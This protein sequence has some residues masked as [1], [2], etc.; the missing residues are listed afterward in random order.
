MSFEAFSENTLAST[1]CSTTRLA[2]FLK[3]QVANVSPADYN[4]DET[5]GTLRYAS[6]AKKIQNTVTRNEDVHER[7][8]RELQEEIERLRGELASGMR[9]GSANGGALSAEQ[10]ASAQ[11]PTDRLRI[12]RV[13]VESG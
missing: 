8:I 9:P 3:T 12:L 7:V 4:T 2:A 10:E 6:R 13:V 1:L 5:V 11:R